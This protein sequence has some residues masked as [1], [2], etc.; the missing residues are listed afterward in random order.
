MSSYISSH[1]NLKSFNYKQYLNKIPFT[2]IKRLEKDRRV[3]SRKGLGDLFLYHLTD[4]FIKQYPPRMGYIEKSI[5]IGERFL[6][7][8]SRRGRKND[9]IYRIIGYYVLSK[10]ARVIERHIAN[11]SNPFSFFQNDDR[12]QK[13][14]KRL[15][16]SR[17]HI[18]VRKS[19]V[20]KFIDNVKKGNLLYIGDRVKK[21]FTKEDDTKSRIKLK[22]FSANGR[23]DS[24]IFYLTID[25]QRIGEIVWL[26]RP[27]YKAHYIAKGNVYSKYKRY[28]KA[29]HKRPRVV[30][31]GGFTNSSRQP[32]GLTIE[33]GTIVNAVLM[34]DRDGLVII[35]KNGAIRV[36]NLKSKSF[37]LPNRRG[38]INP[39][40]SII[41]YAKLIKWSKSNRATFFQTQLLAFS[42]KMLIDKNVAKKTARERRLLALASN[43]KNSQVFHLVVNV[44]KGVSLATITEKTFDIL[45]K[46][47]FKVEAILNLDVGS[48]D[49]MEVYSLRGRRV[50]KAPISISNA[51]NLLFYTQ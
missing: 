32:E 4:S 5:Y 16:K 13:L 37:L 51:T 39:F 11:N 35:Q 27:R 14:R 45:K 12:I 22:T 31:T 29:T 26:Q 19:S 50:L 24:N 17:I 8:K 28:L 34:P 21:I 18:K 23:V 3:A 49:I 33:N 38:K 36:I 42:D 25:N 10:C 47:K 7:F 15:K 30:M 41:D 9:E 1:S 43:R 48:F 44:K 20:G 6:R 2:N 40:N 46:R